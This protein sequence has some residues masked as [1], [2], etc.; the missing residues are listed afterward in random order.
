MDKAIGTL[1]PTPRTDAW[2]ATVGRKRTVTVWSDVIELA[3]F[4]RQLELEANKSRELLEAWLHWGRAAPPTLIY[5]T[6]G[7]LNPS[8]NPFYRGPAAD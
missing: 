1:G 8:G 6:E 2:L 3:D 7:H 4:A 5:R